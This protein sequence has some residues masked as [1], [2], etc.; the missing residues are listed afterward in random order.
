MFCFL[1]VCEKLSKQRP[2][3][4]AT[5]TSYITEYTEK[6]N[7]KKSR[8][9]DEFKTVEMAN[10]EEAEHVNVVNSDDPSKIDK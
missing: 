5:M 3:N 2:N 7:E 8:K 1:Q 4:Y 9:S 10:V 6:Q